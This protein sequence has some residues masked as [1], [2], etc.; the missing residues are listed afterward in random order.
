MKVGAENRHL[1][2]ARNRQ[3][4]KKLTFLSFWRIDYGLSCYISILRHA[5]FQ[6]TLYSS[7]IVNDLNKL[8]LS[9]LKAKKHALA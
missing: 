1:R 8:N 2:Q 5:L 9:R 4:V 7:I 6:A 3:A